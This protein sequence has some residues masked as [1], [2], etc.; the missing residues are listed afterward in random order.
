MGCV[1][2]AHSDPELPAGCPSPSEN[3][4]HEGS[5]YRFLWPVDM[6]S[7]KLFRALNALGSAMFFFDSE[8]ARGALLVRGMPASAIKPRCAP[9]HDLISSD[10]HDRDIKTIL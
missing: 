9:Q 3:I 8:G 1:C 4:S 2:G 6:S 7:L 5:K 10:P